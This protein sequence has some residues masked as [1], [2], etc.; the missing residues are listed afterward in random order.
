MNGGLIF[1]ILDGGGSKALTE[2]T[3]FS[4]GELD[5]DSDETVAMEDAD[6]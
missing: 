5:V 3:G 4:I 1:S 6:R 2:R